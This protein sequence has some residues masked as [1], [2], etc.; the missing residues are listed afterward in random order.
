[1]RNECWIVFGGTQKVDGKSKWKN[2]KHIDRFSLLGLFLVGFLVFAGTVS[3]DDKGIIEEPPTVFSHTPETDTTQV[4]VD[5]VIAVVWDRPMQP[6]TNFTVTGPEG[7][8]QGTF[9]YDQESYTVTFLPD[10]DLTPDTRYG[11]LVA[12]Q[13]DADGLIQEEPYQ[14]HFSTVTPTSVSI[15]SFDSADE[16]TLQSWLWASWPWLM[17][18]V[19]IVSLVGFLG[20]WGRRRLISPAEISSQF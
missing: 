13:V 7:F 17:A 10:E 11:V 12:G 4:S 20:I 15:V 5:V 19:S 8:V 14:W 18:V 3:A 9:R 6:D 2:R 1:L 16:N